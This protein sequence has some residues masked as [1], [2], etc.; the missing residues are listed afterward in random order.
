MKNPVEIGEDIVLLLNG[1]GLSLPD[2]MGALEVAATVLLAAAEL[3]AMDQAQE[4]VQ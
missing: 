1:S 2:Q 4:M 3:D